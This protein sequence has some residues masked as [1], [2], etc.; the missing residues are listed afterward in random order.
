MTRENDFAGY[1]LMGLV[2]L[3][4]IPFGSNPPFFWTLSGL[5]VGLGTAAYFL[6]ALSGGQELRVPLA[7]LRIYIVLWLALAFWLCVQ[8]LPLGTILGPFQFQ[9][10]DGSMLESMSLSLAPD[11]TLLMLV[12]NTSYAL[13]FLL[14]VQAGANGSRA[15]LILTVIFWGIVAH[16]GFSLIQ[17][18]QLGDTSLGFPKT[19]YL[20]V[21]TGTFINRNSFATFLA[22]G[23]TLGAGLIPGL[24]LAPKAR[25]QRPGDTTFKVILQFAGMFVILVALLA[26]QSRMGLFAGLVGAFVVMLLI[27]SRLPRAAISIP[28]AVLVA[29]VL[30]VGA[31]WFYGQGVLTR[32]LDLNDSTVGR[33]DLYQQVMA[34][35]ELRPWLGYGGGAFDVAFP[36]FFGP[37][38]NLSIVYSKAHS[39]YLTLVTELGLVAALLPMILVGLIFVRMVWAQFAASEINGPRIAALGAV[40][41]VAI[42]STVDFSLEIQANAYLLSALGG[43]GL[44]STFAM[45][46]KRAK[47][48]ARVAVN[49][50]AGPALQL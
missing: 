13:L 2:V 46:M 39:T 48:S 49:D 25:N 33:L 20:G 31:T 43:V 22:V 29:L 3:S 28:V 38:L 14:A 23:L 41:V 30:G 15:R 35:I 6:V 16:A 9:L 11:S 26:T 36:A 21:A 18:T 27:L 44:A 42:H 47:T 34:M 12:R 37:P 7:R 45:P 32:A 1:L 19:A 40:I 5:I 10:A 24:I 8:A 17:L 50:G 4:P